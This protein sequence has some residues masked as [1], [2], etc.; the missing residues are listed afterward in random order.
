MKKPTAIRKIFCKAI[1]DATYCEHSYMCISLMDMKDSGQISSVEYVLARAAINAFIKTC[2]DISGYNST[3]MY[4]AIK[5]ARVELGMEYITCTAWEQG[6]GGVDFYNN[7][8]Q[9]HRLLKP[10]RP[11]KARILKKRLA[12]GATNV[13]S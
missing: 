6:G 1:K 13:K 9:R 5:H 2:N 10:K 12:K 11:V 3:C 8:D 7:W 4:W